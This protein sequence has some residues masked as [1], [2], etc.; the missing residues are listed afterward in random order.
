MKKVLIV[1]GAL[2]IGGA[3]RVCAD[4][5]LRADREQFQIDYLVFGE[6]IGAYEPE[7]N[8]RGCSIYHFSPPG[9][10][11]L[12]Y[13]R[14]LLRLL[15][16]QGYDAVHSHTMFN[17]GLN[18]MAAE[19]A[20]VPIRISH[21]H[22][23][24][25]PETRGFVKNSYEKAMRRLILRHATTLAAC[26]RGAGEWLYGKKVFEEKGKLIYNGIDLS[27]AAFRE[28]T[29]RRI[30]NALGV[31]DAFVIG[32][33][34]H[35]APVK[36]QMFL[37]SMLPEL[38]KTNPKTILLLLGDGPDRQKL[39]AETARL[40]LE[41]SVIMTGN[42]SNVGD[43]LSAMDV[44]AFPSLYEGMPLAMIEAQANGLPCLISDRI[45][46]D[47]D[48]TD[49]IRRLAI[50]CAAPWIS[51]LSNAKRSHPEQYE[52]QLRSLDLDTDGMLNNMY[53]LYGEEKHEA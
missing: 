9:E 47:I 32:H 24:K 48:W 44:F 41:K 35:L 25:G 42:V 37:L 3:E 28:E 30:R 31:E 29:R 43:Y 20:G 11:H 5:G 40:G 33:V 13:Y 45:P 8:A 36:N 14:K 51:A 6:N 23:I 18:L 15:K 17:N 1:A 2:C 46:K 19:K 50:D 39:E 52:A 16:E 27:R 34:G 38:L 49:L 21:S 22:S 7:L 26:G 4:I 53:A 12:R 10:N